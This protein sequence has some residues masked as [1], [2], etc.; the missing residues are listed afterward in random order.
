MRTVGDIRDPNYAGQLEASE[1]DAMEILPKLVWHYGEP[2]ADSS[3]IPSFYL[4]KLTR[5]DVTVALNGD[6]GDERARRWTDG[7]RFMVV[8][9]SLDVRGCRGTGRACG[10]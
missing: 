2:F 10:S 6:G 9:Q 8:P 3:A 5:R 7:R 1:P 4:A